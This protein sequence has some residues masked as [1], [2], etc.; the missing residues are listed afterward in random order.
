MAAALN[1]LA[2]DEPVHVGLRSWEPPRL[3]LGSVGEDSLSNFEHS[4]LTHYPT[5]KTLAG[6]RIVESHARSCRLRRRRRRGAESARGFLPDKAAAGPKSRPTPCGQD[7]F[8]SPGSLA[9]FAAMRRASSRLSRI[10][11]RWVP[12]YVWNRG[13]SGSA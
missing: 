2:S 7:G 5:A 12:R 1:A 6:P 8:S 3:Q 10:G 9:M 4:P 11:C 13:I